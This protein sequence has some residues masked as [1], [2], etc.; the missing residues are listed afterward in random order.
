[1][2]SENVRVDEIAEA[3]GV[4]PRTY[5]NYFPSRERAIVAAITTERDERVAA[6]V[7]AR[8]ASAP[9]SDAIV[10]AIVDQ[11]TRAS[12]DERDVLRMISAQPALREAFLDATIEVQDPLE[13]VIAE[14]T[15]GPDQHVAQVLAAAVAA[16]ALPRR[17]LS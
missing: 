13:T 9:L 3:A 8:L 10:E 17:P 7:A 15:G 14:Q 1:M 11:Y 2:Y 4:S 12:D 6:A 5:N 16:Y